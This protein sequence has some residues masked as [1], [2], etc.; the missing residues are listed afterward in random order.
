MKR[1]T[2]QVVK[3]IIIAIVAYVALAAVAAVDLMA[4]PIT[5]IKGFE[6]GMRPAE[7]I[8]NAKATMGPDVEIKRYK[9]KSSESK[10]LGWHVSACKGSPDFTVMGY[11]SQCVVLFTRGDVYFYLEA[12]VA[13]E[14]SKTLGYH[15]NVNSYCDLA[16]YVEESFRQSG[17]NVLVLGRT[18]HYDY[19]RLTAR[20]RA[21]RGDI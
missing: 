18:N 12:G 5:S 8:E 19:I 13:D 15:T 10:Y 2:T 9:P 16:C 21:D 20:P 14:I 17:D 3:D 6:F 4:E 1:T 7:F 11:T